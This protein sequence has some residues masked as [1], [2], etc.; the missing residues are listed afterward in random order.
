[1]ECHWK[2]MCCTPSPHSNMEDRGKELMGLLK[3]LAAYGIMGEGI[4][5]A[6]CEI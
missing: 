1:M 2:I 6:C 3:P 5:V 4:R